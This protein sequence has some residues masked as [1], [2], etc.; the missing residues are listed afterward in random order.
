MRLPNGYGGVTKLSGKRRK[1]YLVRKTIG[2]HYDDGKERVIQD[3]RI[4]GYTATRAEGLQMLAEYNQDPYDLSSNQVTFEDIY[5]KWSAIKY[6][7]IAPSNILGYKSAYKLCVPLYH[8]QFKNI[9]LAD[10]QHVVDTCEKNYPVLKK[11]KVLFHQLYDYALRHEICSK[12]YAEY[13]DIIQYKNRNPNKQDRDKLDNN[14]IER[15]WSQKED[16]YVQTI[17][18]LIYSGVRVS[19]LLNLKKEQIHLKEQYFEVIASKTE[20]GIRSVP[21]AKKVLPFYKSW[22]KSAPECEY[23]IRTPKNLHFLYRNYYLNYFK[24]I[25]EEMGSQQTPHC[26]RHT[27]ISLLA[28]AHV[29]QTIIKKIVGHAGAMSLTEKV[30]THFDVQDLVDAINKI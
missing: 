5:E 19:E 30:Y 25:M 14:D 29:D 4:I 18:M 9:K 13:V 11:L 8:K 3:Y 27:C 20:N 16:P 23:L 22:Y 12:D 2:W 6:C 1:P 15:L 17:L 21:I 7:N 10:L 28:E 24:P 26:C